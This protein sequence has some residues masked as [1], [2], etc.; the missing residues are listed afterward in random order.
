MNEIIQLVCPE[1]FRVEL[2][3]EKE[4][5]RFLNIL[6][7]FLQQALERIIGINTPCETIPDE[8]NSPEFLSL[9]SIRKEIGEMKEKNELNL[10]ELF[11]RQ[12]ENG[13]GDSILEIMK[14]YETLVCEKEKKRNK[15]KTFSQYFSLF[16]TQILL[17]IVTSLLIP[18]Y[19]Q[20]ASSSSSTSDTTY[21]SNECA[22]CQK[23]DDPKNLKKCSRCNQCCYCNVDCQKKTL[24]FPQTCLCQNPIINNHQLFQNFLY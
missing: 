16:R 14:N 2:L 10:C 13:Y 6:F 4:G 5:E 24:V 9:Q 15:P 19:G 20:Q 11:E 18:H 23:K 12:Q 21:K 3:A 1:L 17:N 22:F 7:K 8:E